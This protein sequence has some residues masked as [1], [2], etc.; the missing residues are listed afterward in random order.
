M[1]AWHEAVRQF[2]LRPWDLD[3]YRRA[4]GIASGIERAALRHW[5]EA[6]PPPLRSVDQAGRDGLAA[7]L[8]IACERLGETD[9]ATG[10]LNAAR[11]Y[12][13]TKGIGP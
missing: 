12:D 8:A 11:L 2:A 9:E 4:S 7:A 3:L 13:P 10:Y 6:I 1:E 5:L